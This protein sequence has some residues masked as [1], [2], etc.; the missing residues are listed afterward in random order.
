M[1]IKIKQKGALRRLFSRN[2][3]NLVAAALIASLTVAGLVYGILSALVW[4]V[5]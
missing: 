2:R 5:V 3:L 4:A 1:I